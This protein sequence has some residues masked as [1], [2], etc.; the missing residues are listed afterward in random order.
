MQQKWSSYLKKGQE[1]LIVLSE[2]GNA[3]RGKVSKYPILKVLQSKWSQCAVGVTGF[4]EE[5]LQGLPLQE[6]ITDN[7]SFYTW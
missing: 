2:R 5:V 1:N 4:S 3:E 6:K 7:F